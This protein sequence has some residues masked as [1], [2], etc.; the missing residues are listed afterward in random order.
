[1]LQALAYVIASWGYLDVTLL[2]LIGNLGFLRTEVLV[3]LQVMGFNINAEATAMHIR[4]PW[5][6]TLWISLGYIYT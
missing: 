2:V 1:M 4:F 5:H 3:S 6:Q